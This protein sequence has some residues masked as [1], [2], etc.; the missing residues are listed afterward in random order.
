M[1][2]YEE[3]K[4]WQAL[5]GACF[6]LF[7]LILGALLNSWLA[8]RNERL[9]HADEAH[10]V[11]AA[12]YAEMVAMRDDLARL[13]K[14]TSKLEVGGGLG[15]GPENPFDKHYLEQNR[16][17]APLVYPALVGKIGV[18]PET[19][20][21]DVVTFYNLYAQA[22]HWMPYLGNDKT[23]TFEYSVAWVLRPSFDALTLSDEVLHRLRTFAAI[24]DTPG[25]LDLGDTAFLLELESERAGSH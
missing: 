5:L 24:D 14:H 21:A 16:M 12:L 13:A 3:L 11:A 23:R 1:A 7:A 6:G 2:L 19:T 17:P 4:D 25:G 18:L 9:R 10:A 8:R 22:K 15:H 20:T